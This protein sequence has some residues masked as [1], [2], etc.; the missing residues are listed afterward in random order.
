M[1]LNEMKLGDVLNLVNLLGGK[2]NAEVERDLGKQIIVLHRGWVVAGYVTIKGDMVY[3]K[4]SQCIRRWGRPLGELATI[5][6]GADTV[7]EARCQEQFPLLGV[8]KFIEIKEG[9]DLI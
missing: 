4:D 6:K 9:S 7:L 8:I 5:G 2:A 3:V 1:E